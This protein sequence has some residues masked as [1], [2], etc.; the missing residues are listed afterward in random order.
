MRPSFGGEAEEARRRTGRSSRKVPWDCRLGTG[1]MAAHR[2]QDEHDASV[3][4]SE[5]DV[6]RLP[7][8]GLQWSP[9]AG[10]RQGCP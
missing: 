8:F 6:V 5:T 4:E 7:P 9:P 1:H 2:P 3:R 10:T